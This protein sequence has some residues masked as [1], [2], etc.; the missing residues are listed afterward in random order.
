M[1]VIRQ[2]SIK[3]GFSAVDC[4]LPH[5]ARLCEL[6]Q[7][8]VNGR[9]RYRH[10]SLL[11]LLKQH[12]GCHVPVTLSKKKPTQTDALECQS[13]ARLPQLVLHLR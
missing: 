13:K 5:K 11:G 9:K 7:G 4:D 2:V 6:F 10:A 12:L 8:I 1:M 3:V